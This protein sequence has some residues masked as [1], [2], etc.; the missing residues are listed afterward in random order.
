MTRILMLAADPDK[1]GV[2]RNLVNQEHDAVVQGIAAGRWNDEVSLDSVMA[3]TPDGSITSK[4][5]SVNPHVLHIAAHGSTSALLL[6]NPGGGG[7]E[8]P[9]SAM[10]EIVKAAVPPL[11]LVVLTVCHSETFAKLVTPTVPGVIAMRGTMDTNAAIEFARALHQ[12]LASGY[13]V[14]QSF[15]KARAAIIEV[16][17]PDD[18]VPQLFGDAKALESLVFSGPHADP[19]VRDGSGA[20]QAGTDA[21]GKSPVKVGHIQ[22]MYN[23][24]GGVQQSIEGNVAGSLIGRSG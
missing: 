8:I 21:R 20:K 12:A 17:L 6:T 22:I 19:A 1:A 14:A 10:A 11:K 4:M 16:G 5:T 3:A 2:S 13:S 23:S 24:A 18:G 7:T 15:R 9:H